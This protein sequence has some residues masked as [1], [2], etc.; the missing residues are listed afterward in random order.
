MT[1]MRSDLRL[2]L[3]RSRG[4][5][6][7]A[8]AP[9]GMIDAMRGAVPLD[10]RADAAAAG[11]RR[12]TRTCAAMRAYRHAA[13]DDPAQDRRLPGRQERQPL[14]VLPRAHAHRGDAAPIP[15]SVDA[16]HGPRRQRARRRLAAPLLLHAVPR[17][18]GRGEAAGREP[19]RGLRR[20]A[21][22]RDRRRGHRR[23][24]KPS[25]GDDPAACKRYWT[26][27]ATGRA[28]YFSLGFLT[29]GGFIAG[30]VFWGGFNT[31][32][33]LTN[34]EPFC[35]GCH[36]MRDNVYAG[37]AAARS[38]SRNRSGVRAN[39]P[40]CHVPHDWTDK[41]ARKMQASQG[42]LGQ[43]LR[44]DQHAREVRGAPAELAQ[45]EWA[46][47]KA[48]DSLECRNC[49][50]FDYMDFTRQ[51]PRAAQAALDAARHRRADLHR[52]P[53]GHR[54]P[55]AAASRPADE[56]RDAALA[57]VTAIRSSRCRPA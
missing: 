55:A 39:C 9:Q 2:L 20:S 29:V 51:S 37:A 18:A 43:D 16:L 12:R 38:T 22:E 49:H 28:G 10:D 33:E 34:T 6:A 17:A 31:A 35:I 47:L 25:A 4:R 54:A 19:L 24:R 53:Q 27:R 3:A 8:P 5:R 46:R 45:H 44:H 32:L 36:E 57:R 14:H 56:R 26:R 41:I 11:K 15:V 21:R 50:G 7:S 23:A 1:T 30:I 52:L 40:D 48:N 13:A 42:S